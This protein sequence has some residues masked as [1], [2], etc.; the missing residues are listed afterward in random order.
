MKINQA[1]YVRDECMKPIG[2][3]WDLVKQSD[4][5]IGLINL[6]DELRIVVD[7]LKML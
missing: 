7:N 1:S 4:F 3:E 5:F 2:V 6:R